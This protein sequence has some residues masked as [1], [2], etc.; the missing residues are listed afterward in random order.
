MGKTLVSVVILTKNEETRIAQCLD[1]VREWVD[2]VIVVDDESLDA[3]ATIAK[4][5][6]AKV[7][8]KKMQVEGSHRNW[9]YAQSKNLWILSIDADERV[10]EELKKEI[11]DMLRTDPAEVVFTIP[12]RNFIGDYWIRWGGMYPAAQ[13]KLFRKDRFRWEEVEVHP[14]ASYEGECGHLKFDLI[15][16]TYRDW[17]DFLKKLNSQTTLEAIKWHKLSLQNPEKAAYK[18][19]CFHALWRTFD[20]FIRGFFV[21]Q[22]FRDGFIGFMVAYFA[23][24][25]QIVSYAKYRELKAKESES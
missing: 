18:M 1:S 17:Q 10:T 4:N 8:I 24:L 13:I 25:Y 22:G 23:S 11:T 5:Y 12:R 9:A 16:L 21:K 2:E 6:G 7:L 15:H 20:R 14:R 19:N 3:T